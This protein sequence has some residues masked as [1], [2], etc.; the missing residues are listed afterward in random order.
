MDRDRI[1]GGEV[2]AIPAGGLILGA[3]SQGR[4]ATAPVVRLATSLGDRIVAVSHHG[5][6]YK[7]GNED[8]IAVVEGRL[9]GVRVTGLFVVDGM[10]GHERGDVAAQMLSEELNRVVAGTG[11]DTD[12]EIAGVIRDRVAELVAELPTPRLVAA[13]R[14]HLDRT[15]PA[16]AATPSP[17]ELVQTALRAVERE[18]LEVE[19]ATPESLQR[20]AQVIRAL[21]HLRP[22]HPVEIAVRRTRRRIAALGAVSS[23]P[24]ACLIG[25]VISEQPDGRRLLDVHQIG[26]CKLVVASADGTVKFQSIAESMLPCPDLRRQDLTLTELMAYSLHRNL[27]SNSVNSENLRFKSYRQVD[28]PVELAPGDLVCAYSDGVDDLFTPE[29]ILAWRSSDDDGEL[30]RR[31]LEASERRMDLVAAQ[32]QVER[33]GLPSDLKMRAYPIVHERLN[34]VRLERGAYVERYRDGAV[35]RWSKPPKCDNTAFCML[36]VGAGRA[37]AAARL[38]AV[39]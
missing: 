12:R 27:V 34:L 1:G 38:A 9:G 35:G 33:A 37:V 17:T 16:G 21:G 3:K 28:V 8:R 22:P 26:D 15:E 32:L 30:L 10:G 25:A 13:V 23:P 2:A 39:G 18:S 36:E 14:A 19:Q 5:V 4:L 29:E 20:I 6:G 11:A 24:D 7:P 31:L